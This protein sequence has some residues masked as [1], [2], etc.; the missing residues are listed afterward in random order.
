MPSSSLL[1]SSFIK[2]IF[3]DFDLAV[4]RSNPVV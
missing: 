1:G 4:I 3:S 2:D